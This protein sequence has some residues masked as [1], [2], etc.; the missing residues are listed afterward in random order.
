MASGHWKLA[1]S[2]EGPLGVGKGAGAG[3]LFPVGCGEDG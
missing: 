2:A 3:M 1:K